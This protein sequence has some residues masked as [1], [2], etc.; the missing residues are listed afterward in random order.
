[1]RIQV[2]KDFCSKVENVYNLNSIEFHNIRKNRSRLP[3]HFDSKLFNS[4]YGMT[5]EMEMLMRKLNV[6]V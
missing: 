6:M 5:V 3:T 1:M 4:L 2:L